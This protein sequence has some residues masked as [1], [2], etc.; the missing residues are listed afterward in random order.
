MKKF[1]VVA[2]SVVML[3]SLSNLSLHA[4]DTTANSPSATQA[5]N[6]STPSATTEARMSAVVKDIDYQKRTVT[7][8]GA[9]GQ[10]TTLDVGQDV[11]RFNAIKK[12]DRVQVRYLE[13]IALS[14]GKPGE[15]TANSE[16][17]TFVRAPGEKPSGTQV[18]TKD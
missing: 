9:D 16:S 10:E 15:Q 4:N 17:Q 13:S 3:G 6:T 11:Q 12:G 18:T 5:Q 2:V 14:L 1:G 8:L 7:L